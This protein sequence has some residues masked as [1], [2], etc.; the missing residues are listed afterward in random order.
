MNF[1]APEIIAER[2]IFIDPKTPQRGVST[3][4]RGGY[5][6]NWKPNSLGSIINQ[7]KSACTKRIWKLE[8]ITFSW[9]PKF[10]D[11]IIR[12]DE[13]LNKIRE[14]IITYPQMWER[15]RNMPENVFM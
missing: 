15:D 2:S 11:H 5:N 1:N 4:K 10:Y 14:Y 6:P 12:N 8:S 3:K 13:S 7:F 9:Q